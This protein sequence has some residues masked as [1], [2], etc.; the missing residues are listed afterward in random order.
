MPKIGAAARGARSPLVCFSDYS[1]SVIPGLASV[2][3]QAFAMQIN[4][5]PSVSKCVIW[6]VPDTVFDALLF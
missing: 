3:R 1:D 5:P 6:N 4:F 2:R